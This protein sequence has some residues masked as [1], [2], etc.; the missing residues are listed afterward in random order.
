MALENALMVD[1]KPTK[2]Q[3]ES[4]KLNKKIKLEWLFQLSINLN[5]EII[6]TSIQR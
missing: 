3:K 2:T 1:D 6:K 5:I 4:I